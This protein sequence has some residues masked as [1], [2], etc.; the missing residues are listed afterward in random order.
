MD[1]HTQQNTELTESEIAQFQE[2]GIFMGGCQE[3][4]L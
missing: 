1:T 4:D 3:S 2:D